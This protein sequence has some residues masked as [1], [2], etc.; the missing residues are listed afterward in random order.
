MNTNGTLVLRALPMQE[1][2]PSGEEERI[3]AL[4]TQELRQALADSLSI[5]AASLLRL[6]LIVRTLEERG[7]DISELRLPLLTYLRQIASGRLWPPV[8]ARFA[9]YPPLISKVAGLPL[10][11][12]QALA[13]GETVTLVVRQGD[14]WTDRQHD[15]TKLDNSQRLQVFANDHKRSKEE[16]ILW[17]ESR[18]MKNGTGHHK[19]QPAQGRVRP[20]RER[21]GLVVG[22]TF[23]K[24]SD[25]LAALGGL[26]EDGEQPATEEQLVTMALKV[27]E[28]EHRALKR[29]ALDNDT[30][31]AE[32]IRRA[33]RAGGLI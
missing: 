2:L 10:T 21:G 3:V 19:K 24:Q 29:R 22:R 31:M 13:R 4:S 5:T 12:Q 25:V 18:A 17:L 15:P 28:T 14:V 20:D 30:T 6:A 1:L 27:S 7:E 32:L 23:I 9:E 8:V 16:Q 26:V 11:D 33:M